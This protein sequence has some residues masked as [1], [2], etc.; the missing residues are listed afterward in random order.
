MKCIVRYNKCEP[1][2]RQLTP[3][4]WMFFCPGCKCGHVFYVEEPS[5]ERKA[6][7]KFN[8]NESSPTFTP[9]LLYD[10]SKPRCHSYVTNGMIQFLPDCEHELRGQTVPLPE[11]W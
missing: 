10:T 1:K 11:E 2:T 9:S 6:Q 5:P 4:G 3:V 7:W 8:G